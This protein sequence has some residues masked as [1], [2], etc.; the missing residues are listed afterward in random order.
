MTD[1]ADDVARWNMAAGVS[2][3]W[4]VDDIRLAL[5]LIDE[6]MSRELR[7]PALRLSNDDATALPELADAIADSIVV[8]LGLAYR[9]GIDVAPVFDEVMRANWSKLL[10]GVKRRD[11]GKILKGPHYV[12]PDVPAAIKRG[13]QWR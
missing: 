10:G 8:L 5:E 6:E 11:D 7:P 3:S 2:Q 13:R 12:A 4:A 1:W 9:V